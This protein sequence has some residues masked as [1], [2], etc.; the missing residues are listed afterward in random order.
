MLCDCEKDNHLPRA[1]RLCTFQSKEF[2]LEQINPCWASHRCDVLRLLFTSFG[3][4]FFWL[5]NR[6]ISGIQI[7]FEIPQT[8]NTLRVTDLT[9]LLVIQHNFANWCKNPHCNRFWYIW[10]FK[11]NSRLFDH[12]FKNA[13]K[14]NGKIVIGTICR[15]AENMTHSWYSICSALLGESKWKHSMRTGKK[16]KINESR[17]VNLCSVEN[18]KY[19]V[20]HETDMGWSSC[21][22]PKLYRYKRVKNAY[23]L[24]FE[25]RFRSQFLSQ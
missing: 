3:E 8:H 22:F 13:M 18:F 9:Q 25:A 23:T 14:W 12:W 20:E 1:P 19:L 16:K 2:R 21:S 10:H 5:R 11:R 24:T 4:N 15:I 7:N 17:F 6:F